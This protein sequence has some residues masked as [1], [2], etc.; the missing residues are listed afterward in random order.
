[1]DKRFLVMRAGATKQRAID[2]EQHDCPSRSH[3][4]WY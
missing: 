1:V 3:A 2:I 4:L